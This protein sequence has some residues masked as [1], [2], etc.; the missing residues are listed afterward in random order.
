LRNTVA[1]GQLSTVVLPL[2]KEAD[3]ERLK[4]EVQVK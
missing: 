1:L 3:S 2:N 4:Y